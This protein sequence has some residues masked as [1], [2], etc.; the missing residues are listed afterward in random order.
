[1]DELRSL[2]AL[3][4]EYGVTYYTGLNSLGETV[5]VQLGAAPAAVTAVDLTKDGFVPSTGRSPEL[6]RMLRR[7][8]P[9]YSDPALFDIK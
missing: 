9:Q 4:R 5:T 1:M 3:L 7:L 6:E 8:D 2:L